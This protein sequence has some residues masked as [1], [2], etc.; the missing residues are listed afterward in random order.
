MATQTDKTPAPAAAKAPEPRTVAEDMAA[1][2][3]FST[4]DEAKAY[5]EKCAGEYA[6]FDSQTFAMPGVNDEGEFDPAIYSD[7]M[8]VM[9]ALLRKDKGI[10][11]IVVTAIPKVQTILDS[12][13]GRAWA[14]KILHKELNHVAVRPLREAEDVGAFVDQMPTSLDA[15]LASGRD[16]GGIMESFNE[17]Y[18]AISATMSTIPVWGKARGSLV[19]SELK[20]AFESAGYASEYYPSLEGYEAKN[21]DK[22]LFVTALLLGISSAKRKGLDP[23]IFERWLATRDQKVFT[24]GQTDDDEDNGLDIDSLTSALM[25]ANDETKAEPAGDAA[26]TPA[27][28]EPEPVQ[29][30]EPASTPEPDSEPAAEPAT[31]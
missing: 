2:R 17:L 23:T 5:L 3:V 7:S 8:D 10:K 4:T 27:A 28:T 29:T 26:A 15:Y 6:D 1:R 21:V 19:K 14:T 12:E 24:P 22:G 11:A 13:A 25:D 16:A 20:R 18:K 31:A 9:V 30:D